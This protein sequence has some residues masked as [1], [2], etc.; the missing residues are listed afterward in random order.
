MKQKSGDFIDF[1]LMMKRLAVGLKSF[2]QPKRALFAKLP[3]FETILMAFI[4]ILDGLPA[5]SKH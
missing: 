2:A 4:G 5:A 1:F 3:R